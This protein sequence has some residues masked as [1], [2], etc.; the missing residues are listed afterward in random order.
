MK[1]KTKKKKEIHPKLKEFKENLKEKQAKYKAFTAKL[2]TDKEFVAD[3]AKLEKL[4]KREDALHKEVEILGANIRNKFLENAKH[5]SSPYMR[6]RD[7]EKQCNIKPSLLE[8]I[9][10]FSESKVLTNNQKVEFVSDLIGMTQTKEGYDKMESE[11]DKVYD[12]RYDLKHKIREKLDLDEELKDE[13]TDL[14]YNI[15]NFD[16]SDY[17]EDT[18]EEENEPVSDEDILARAKAIKK[19]QKE[20][21]REKAFQKLNENKE[22]ILKLMLEEK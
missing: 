6:V 2:K 5:W 8:I 4:V 12:E 13:I 18:E 19:K 11:Y 15:K 16:P 3:K 9:D 21:E 1:K 7:G 22:T 10:E 20:E 17:E 14:K